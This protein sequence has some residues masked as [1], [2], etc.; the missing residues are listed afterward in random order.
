MT[1]VAMSLALIVIT[2]DL[3]ALNVAVPAMQRSFHSDISTMQWAL[4]GYAL[5]FGVLMVTGGRL[6]DLLGRRRVFL[7]GTAL[8]G[9]A[10]A[11]GGLA[12]DAWWMIGARVIMGVAGALMLPAATGI[13]YA[14]LPPERAG[15]AG[16]VAV[17]SF[18]I[19]QSIGPLIGGALTE[20]LS[21]R[22]VFFIDI[23]AAALT[24]LVAW[25]TVSAAAR[26]EGS[27]RIDYAGSVVLSLSLLALLVALDEGNDW[28]WGSG[29][30]LAAYGIF[31]VGLAAFVLAERRAGE[32]A[33][34]PANVVGSRAFGAACLVA[35][36]GAPVFFSALFYL[37]QFMDKL[38]GY[39]PFEIGI[40]TLPMMASLAV[41]SFVA[42][43]LYDRVG[44][45]AVLL[46]GNAAMVAGCA[47]LGFVGGDA[48]TGLIPGMVVLGAGLA[49]FA[50]SLTTVAVTALSAAQRSLAG[51][52]I[53]TIRVVGGGL[54]LGLTTAIVAS[55]GEH[56]ARF[57]SGFRDGFRVNAALA[58]AGL[59]VAL[60]AVRTR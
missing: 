51:G 58:L 25:R 5:A 32:H 30:V 6:A 34:L 50:S 46:A 26:T 9:L 15:L 38:L 59:T 57:L 7:L 8:F 52:I 24:F 49:F 53:F 12:T 13:L 27:R 14:T 1:I 36:L 4:N 29:R 43:P 40:G 48:Y 41:C 22:W 21:W 31:A 23:P 60:V 35:L 11:L 56:G 37:P 17:G 47:L 3:S 28:G 2:L 20:Y 33:L 18:G 39:S 19:G 16:A 44:A 10:A 45:K 55:S 42:G 54:G